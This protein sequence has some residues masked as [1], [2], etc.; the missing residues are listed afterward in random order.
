MDPVATR[1]ND[2]AA[3]TGGHVL[4]VD[5]DS[6]LIDF[7]LRDRPPARVVQVVLSRYGGPMLDCVGHKRL[8]GRSPSGPII[9]GL[10]DGLRVLQLPLSL[11]SS[12]G[13]CIVI[14]STGSIDIAWVVGQA[15]E[16]SALLTRRAAAS[17][18]VAA[19]LL[20]GTAAVPPMW[21]DLPLHCALLH[22]E[23]RLSDWRVAASRADACSDHISATALPDGIGLVL[24]AAPDQVDAVLER[25]IAVL[26]TVLESPVT[27][28]VAGPVARTEELPRLL[29]E[30][31]Q[32]AEL[33]GPGTIVR[34]ASVTSALDVRR[35]VQAVCHDAGFD[36][37][38]HLHEYDTARGGQLARSLLSW[39][40]GVGDT[41]AVAERLGLHANT[42]RYRIRR[43]SDLLRIDLD[44]VDARLSIHLRLR[45]WASAPREAPSFRP[46]DHLTHRETGT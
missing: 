18:D 19:Q 14:G 29:E 45:G 5:D 30:V 21:A 32:A 40:D 43:A 3:L 1:L 13:T 23:A 22:A 17:D 31:R 7:A 2:V 46:N 9:S 4:V 41:A 35:A 27:G 24:A 38:E 16:L 20:A 12:A 33:A 6:R 36:P 8:E 39:L 11:G 37:L 25:A 15:A 34:T 26:A 44:D 42:L 10:M 28:A